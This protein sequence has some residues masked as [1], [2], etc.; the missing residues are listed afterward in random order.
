MSVAYL[1]RLRIRT[2]HSIAQSGSAAV[3][4]VVISFNSGQIPFAKLQEMMEVT[5]SPPTRQYLSDK[6]HHRVSASVMKAE[7]QVK[8]GGSL[9]T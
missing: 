1:E 5:V 6:D 8:G 4:L 9:Y 7:T 2:S 3:N